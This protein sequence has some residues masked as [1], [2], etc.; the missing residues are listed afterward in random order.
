M[1]SPCFSEYAWLL[2]SPTFPSPSAL[3][4]SPRFKSWIRLFTVVSFWIVSFILLS[5]SFLICKGRP[6]FLPL[7]VYKSQRRSCLRTPVDRHKCALS[8]T[9]CSHQRLDTTHQALEKWINGATFIQWNTIYVWKQVDHS[10][11]VVTIWMN[12]SKATVS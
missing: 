9:V 2:L 4:R 7:Y 10:D 1:K 12:L 3:H 8:S 5:L 6:A 11:T